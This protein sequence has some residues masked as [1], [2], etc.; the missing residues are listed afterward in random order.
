MDVNKIASRVAYGGPQDM[1]PEDKALQSSIWSAARPHFQRIYK[2]MWYVPGEGLEGFLVSG[3]EN[4]EAEL[5]ALA[6]KGRFTIRSEEAIPMG[7]FKRIVESLPD[8]SA[9]RP[10]RR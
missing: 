10:R 3:S 5:R 8:P 1:L 7:E 6:A 9:A 2:V 4:A